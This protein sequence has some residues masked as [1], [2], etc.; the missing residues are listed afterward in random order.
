MQVP[1][2]GRGATF[3]RGPGNIMLNDLYLSHESPKDKLSANRFIVSPMFQPKAVM[4][5]TARLRHFSL[6]FSETIRSCP[7]SEIAV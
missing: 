5:F 7:G 4:K 1:T 2:A 6:V 3:F